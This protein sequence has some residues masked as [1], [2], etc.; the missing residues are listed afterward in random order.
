MKLRKRFRIAV[1]LVLLS[2]IVVAA[3]VA[4]H[5]P[6]IAALD[7]PMRIDGPD[8]LAAPAPNANVYQRW[9]DS[10]RPI[11]P[12]APLAA[13]GLGLLLPN[14]E[15]GR[16]AVV[17]IPNYGPGMATVQLLRLAALPGVSP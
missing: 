2:S 15:V 3:H 10:L 9:D 11:P 14:W 5:P 1:G 12:A 13:P 6:L 8:H 7:L 16:N 4:A 17:L